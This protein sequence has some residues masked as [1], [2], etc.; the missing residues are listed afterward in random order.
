MSTNPF[1]AKIKSN[2]N[3]Y[4]R[5]HNSVRVVNAN[6]RN[7]NGKRDEKRFEKSL[8]G[9]QLDT[10]PEGTKDNPAGKTTGS[11]YPVYAG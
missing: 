5:K 2:S 6:D 7:R 3:V 4:V 10:K 9:R 11:T 8:S 1:Y